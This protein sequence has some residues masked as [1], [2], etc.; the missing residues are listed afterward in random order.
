MSFSWEM[1]VTDLSSEFTNGTRIAVRN[2]LQGSGL[3]TSWSEISITSYRTILMG[4]KTANGLKS[5]STLGIDLVTWTAK[6]LNKVAQRRQ[7]Q[8][9]D[10]LRPLLTF[11]KNRAAGLEEDTT[12]VINNQ[13]GE[14]RF[15][16][17]SLVPVIQRRRDHRSGLS[18]L[19]QMQTKPNKWHVWSFC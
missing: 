2:Q 16:D 1:L 6:A 7:G 9:G 17:T 4:L 11:S 18:S 14:L 5:W 10:V 3:R 8:A 19:N 13:H 15:C 12:I